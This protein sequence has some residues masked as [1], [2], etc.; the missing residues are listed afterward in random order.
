V[1]ATAVYQSGSTAI[2]VWI[3]NTGTVSFGMK[4][5]KGVAPNGTSYAGGF[6]FNAYSADGTF[7]CGAGSCG[8]PPP[9]ANGGLLQITFDVNGARPGSLLILTYTIVWS[10][11]TAGPQ[12]I[13]FSVA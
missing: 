9:T 10:G 11:Q 6:N 3:R 2:T 7:L 5:I 4:S 1:N 8:G 13:S 12:S